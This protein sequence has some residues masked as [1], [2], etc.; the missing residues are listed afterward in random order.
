MA[1]Y[2]RIDTGTVLGSGRAPLPGT[3][4]GLARQLLRAAWGNQGDA[5]VR[6]FY[7]LVPHEFVESADADI[8]RLAQQDVIGRVAK[9]LV[10]EPRWRGGR[11][12]VAWLEQAG[13]SR[14]GRNV[15][16]A[17]A[18]LWEPGSPAAE[19]VARRLAEKVER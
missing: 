9:L 12:D 13:E 15:H 4:P 14:L 8:R 3:E 5:A 1:T 7:K 10:D 19:I 18:A 6:V 11:I 16:A 2:D 17:V